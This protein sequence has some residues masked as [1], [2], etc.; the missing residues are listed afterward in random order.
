MAEEESA[1]P[2]FLAWVKEM[3]DAAKVRNTRADFTRL[4]HPSEAQALQ[5]IGPS[6]C[7]KLT[8]KLEEYCRQNGLPMPKKPR[9]RKRTNSVVADGHGDTADEPRAAPKRKVSKKLYVP[10]RRGGAYG[11]LYGLGT[12]DKGD[13]VGMS[14]SELIAVAQPYSDSSY[15]IPQPGSSHHTAWN[16][17]KTLINHGLVNESGPRF[18]RQ[19]YLSEQGW[20]VYNSMKR[21]ELGYSTEN[22][23]T[24]AVVEDIR[25][26][27]ASSIDPDLSAISDVTST[28]NVTGDA[29]SSCSRIATYEPVLIPSDAFTVELIIDHRE[30]R[31][32]NDR[33]FFQK[34]FEEQG[35]TTYC[36]ALGLGDFV[37][38][39]KLKDP[40]FLHKYGDG[41]DEVMLSHI[42]E[43][44]R[45]SDLIE[46]I[47]SG[48]FVEQ[49]FRLQRS[50]IQ[51]IVYIIEDST[52]SD[53]NQMNYTE[54]MA[55]AKARTMVIDKFFV[56]ETANINDTVK[57]LTR[58][59]LQLRKMFTG[60]HATRILHY[61][62]TKQIRGGMQGYQDMIS[63]F[64]SKTDSRTNIH[65]VAFPTFS[66]LC[67]KSKMLTLRDIYLKML[68]SIR[69]VSAEK[70]LAI[71]RIWPVPKALVKALQDEVARGGRSAADTLISDRLGQEIGPAKVQKV[72]SRK[73][74]EVWLLS[75]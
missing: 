53:M 61:I 11:L 1:N 6:I 4:E 65:V 55:S 15:T 41:A 69:G 67:S 26:E 18:G 9:G 35:I 2:L 60:P 46:S 58:L 75:G 51:N 29:D 47:K 30:V 16:S 33:N 27:S 21:A 5:G 72:L 25:S 28:S 54:H 73:I 56:K 31:A 62:P 36:R 45:K 23:A 32:R 71:Q 48:R 10:R 66:F 7:E 52:L 17:M 39:A 14:R 22:A 34:A 59:T 3:W 38:V 64:R 68:M 74:A 19:Y 70:A 50:G 40:S 49:K 57:Y 8:E 44:K 24:E 43:R 12:V 63:H 20:K 42:V 37:W 13:T